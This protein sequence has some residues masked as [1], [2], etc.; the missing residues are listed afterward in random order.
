MERKEILEDRAY[1]E[2]H[3]MQTIDGKATGNFWR[4]TDV[5]AGIKDYHKLFSN[6]KPQAFALGRVSMEESNNEKPLCQLLLTSPLKKGSMDCHADKS[7]R[8]DDNNSGLFNTLSLNKVSSSS[9]TTPTCRRQATSP[10]GEAL[11][12]PST[13]PRCSPSLAGGA[14][15]RSE[16]E[17]VLNENAKTPF[18]T[19]CHFPHLRG[20]RSSLFPTDS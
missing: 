13:T 19:A 9:V 8:N 17:G 10:Q 4:K 5:W 7:A 11:E 20:G 1:V 2:I 15:E 6:L 18:G 3:M 14:A 16:A 12:Q